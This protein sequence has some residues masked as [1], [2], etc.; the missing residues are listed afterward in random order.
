MYPAIILGIF[1]FLFFFGIL[2]P[3]ITT[4]MVYVMLSVGADLFKKEIP[5]KKVTIILIMAFVLTAIVSCG[6]VVY[7]FKDQP[8][9][10]D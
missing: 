6:S 10:F 8:I 1:L 9:M 7:Y 3:A 2:I 4:S 5:K